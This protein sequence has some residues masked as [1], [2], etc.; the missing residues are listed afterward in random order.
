[1][2]INST[3]EKK[4]TAN[5]EFVSYTGKYPCLC[6]G[7]LTLRICGEEC[8]FGSDAKKKKKGVGYF[9]SFWNSGG[10]VGFSDDYSVEYVYNEEWLIDVNALPEKFR[11][12][13]VEIDM[14]FNAN[15]EHGCCGGCL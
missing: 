1:M 14:V 4:K 8:V 10:R 15:V 2:I 13:A 5:V 6:Y 11:Q 12:Y 9:D 3:D 7:E